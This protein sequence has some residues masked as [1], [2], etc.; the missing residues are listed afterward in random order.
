M[1]RLPDWV[2][3]F[4]SEIQKAERTPFDWAKNNCVTF[5]AD[6]LKAILGVDFMPLAK[7]RLKTKRGALA[8]LKRE[9]GGDLECLAAKTFDG[10]FPEVPPAYAKRGDPVVLKMPDGSLI[11]SI[12]D[13]SGG[14]A[15]ALNV[16]GS[17]VVR[18][19]A[20]QAIR[21]WNA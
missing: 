13:L 8:A 10:V 3:R 6:C 11:I 17:G 7:R 5:T 1:K 2:E 9:C 14:S 15:V 21:A 18:V 20:D 16:D 19:P 4:E 12:I